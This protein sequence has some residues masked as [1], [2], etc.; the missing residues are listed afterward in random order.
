MRK[1]KYILILCLMLVL[2]VDGTATTTAHPKITPEAVYHLISKSY[3]LHND[4]SVDYRFRKEL[5]LFTNSSFDT[6]GETFIL[7]NPDFQTLTINEAYV[8]R[9]DGSI[10]QTPAN[11]FNPSLPSVCA[12]CERF[13]RFRE[14]VVTHTALEYDA[15]IVLDYT[16]HSEQPFM[17]G[18][19]E[20]V[21]LYEQ[22]PVEKYDI[23]VTFPPDMYLN[24]F[25]NY[26][27]YNMLRDGRR[28]PDSAITTHWLFTDLPQ[29]PADEYLPETYKP[30]LSFTT[31]SNP[32]DFVGSIAMQ[33]AFMAYSYNEYEDVFAAILN[34]TMSE[35]EQ[36]L[37]IR[38]YVA[39]NIRLNSIPA[40]YLNYI[41]ATPHDTW[42]THCGTAL[43]KT[44]LLQS[45]LRAH[46]YNALAGF[47]H[48]D[49][50]RDLDGVVR[51]VISDKMFYLSAVKKNTVSLE[52]TKAP[53]HFISML[54][55]MTFYDET[56]RQVDV[57]ATVSIERD[58]EKVWAEVDDSLCNIVSPET[59]TLP[60]QKPTAANAFV[61]SLGKG[62][63]QLQITDGGYGS[64]IRSA[65]L[66]RN[67]KTPVVVPQSDETYV[68]EIKL[69]DGGR[70]ITRETSCEINHGFGS[71]HVSVYFAG[72]S[73]FLQRELHLKKRII[74]PMEYRDFRKMIAQW[75]AVPQLIFEWP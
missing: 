53:C 15:T 56:P 18:I 34:D 25:T 19:M 30:T 32:L 21:N 17:K 60:E 24:Y 16:I 75:E 39:D 69:P 71:E 9:K 45:M 64:P 6:Y 72:K 59:N 37:A 73:L 10:V 63:Y 62:F 29:C 68:Y 65:Y 57:A 14:M 54:G 8:I 36:I 70:W 3:K 33:N 49:M 67:R 31:I 35:M 1:I 50:M 61:K 41:V 7:F 27:G 11:A 4:G 38:D 28:E 43:E 74:S 20:V 46:H 48:E 23:T 51:V 55:D 5:Q 26:S 47:W 52:V 22:A 42:T 12:N 58:D 40:R 13:N 44:L 66:P 2:S